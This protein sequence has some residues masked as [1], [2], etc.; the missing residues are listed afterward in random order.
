MNLSRPSRAL[1]LAVSLL[2]VA[3][4]GGDRTPGTPT[5]P[6]AATPTPPV[7]VTPPPP[8]PF[9][10]ASSCGRIGLGSDRYECREEAAS[11]LGEVRA[12]IDELVR[13]KPGLFQQTDIG[14]QVQSRGQFYVGIIEKLD[15]KGLCAA[16]DGEEL[17][18]KSDNSFND[19]YHLVTSASIVRQGGGSYQVTCY[20]AAFPTPAPPYPP[21]NGCSLPSSREITCGLESA[22]YWTEIDQALSQVAREHPGVF[23]LTDQRGEGGYR[24]VNP[25]GFKAALFDAMRSRGYC[26]RHDGEEFVF[27]KT[28]TFTEHYDLESSA[29]YLRRGEGSYASTCYPAAF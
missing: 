24:I 21:S 28:N 26:A 7:A 22:S 25:D 29:G 27:K 11:F 10:G 3:C 13:E 18:V 8:D 12:A 17:G 1:P 9:P 5:S 14:L 4:G 2:L 23:D 6:A 16:F 19:Q 15:R 20:P